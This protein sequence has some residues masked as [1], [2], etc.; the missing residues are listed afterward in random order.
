MNRAEAKKLTVGMVVLADTNPQGTSYSTKEPVLIAGGLE[1]FRVPNPRYSWKNDQTHTTIRVVGINKVVGINTELRS[2][3]GDPEIE[4][5]FPTWGGFDYW[6]GGERHKV[7]LTHAP[8]STEVQLNVRHLS[9]VHQWPDLMTYKAHK[10]QD[11]HQRARVEEHGR[12]VQEWSEHAEAKAKGFVGDV[13]N[14]A[15]VRSIDGE[16]RVT[17]TVAE[18]GRMLMLAHPDAVL[19]VKLPTVWFGGTRPRIEDVR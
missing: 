5:W 12:R 4:P 11:D 10:A 13:G 14:K 17:A 15:L 3:R 2:F 1:I 9:A 6:Q 19:T 16:V 18:I 7:G 8:L